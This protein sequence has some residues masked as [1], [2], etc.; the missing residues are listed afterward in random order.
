M[1]ATSSHREIAPGAEEFLPPSAG[2]W[3]PPERTFSHVARGGFTPERVDHVE[4]AAERDVA[5]DIVVGVRAFRQRV[6]DQIVTLFGVAAVDDAGA[7]SATTTSDRPAISKRS[8]WGVSVSRAVVDGVR[9]SVDYT[10]AD[11]DWSGR[12]RR[13]RGAR[14]HGAAGAAS[15]D[16]RIHDLTR[17]S[18]AWCRR[19]DACLRRL[20]D[21]LRRSRRDPASSR[22]RPAARASTCRSTRRCRS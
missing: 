3:L 17:R 18:R 22:P 11:A 2:L 7:A 4:V 10:Q 14:A 12:S 5:G 20:Q 1:R 8:G 15:A 9:A 19:R 21:E 16:E 6:D 13:L